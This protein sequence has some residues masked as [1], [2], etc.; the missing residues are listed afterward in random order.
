[1]SGREIKKL[2]ESKADLERILAEIEEDLDSVMTPQNLSDAG[3]LH[4]EL[5]VLTADDLLSPFTI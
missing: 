1:M 5:C 4:R 3:K 2:S